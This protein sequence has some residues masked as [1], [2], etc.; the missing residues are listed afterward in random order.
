MNFM[1]VEKKTQMLLK[2][3][4]FYEHQQLN[5]LIASSLKA[6]DRWHFK[7]LT[8]K[9]TRLPI[10]LAQVRAGNKKKLTK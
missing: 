4:Y 5:P 2:V 10:A 3:E 9:Q 6:F 1:K 7:I 8:A